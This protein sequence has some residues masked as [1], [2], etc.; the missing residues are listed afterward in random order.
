MRA[1]LAAVVLLAGCGGMQSGRDPEL[2]PG[3]CA[4]RCESV[5]PQLKRDFNFTDLNCA[6]LAIVGAT[7]EAA[8]GCALQRATNGLIGACGAP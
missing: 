1:C 6:N 8:C 2:L 4:S 5:R 3:A 7:S